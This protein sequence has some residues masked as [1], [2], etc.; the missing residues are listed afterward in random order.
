MLYELNDVTVSLSGREILTHTGMFI[1]GN[2]KIALVGKNG[3][4]K[5][6]LLNLIMG[7][8]SPDRDDKRTTEAV[9]QAR[10]L[11]IEILDQIPFK[12]MDITFYEALKE[13]L[14]EIEE[15]S[16]EYFDREYEIDRMLCGLGLD[17]EDKYKNISCFSGG[18]IT[19]LGIICLLLKQPDILLLDE[20]TNHLDLAGIEW[21]EEY[22][23]SF[24]GAVIMISHDRFFLDSVADVT[25]ELED[26]KL[27]RYAGGY[28]EYKKEKELRLAALQKAYDRYIAEKSRLEELDKRFKSRPN[29]AA[30]ARAKRSQLERLEEVKPPKAEGRIDLKSLEQPAHPGPKWVFEAEHLKIGYEKPLYETSLR[31]KRGEKIGVIGENGSGKSTLIKTVAGILPAISGK[32]T[33]GNNVK[34]GYY[35]QM[36]SRIYSEKNLLEHFGEKF[37]SLNEGEIRKKLAMWRFFGADVYKK[38]D[39]LS[40]GEKA[41]LVM[42]ELLNERPNFLIL[43]EPTNHMD[44]PAKEALEAVLKNYNAAMLIVSH[45]RYFI[46]RLAGS[47]IITGGDD[48]YCYPFGYEHYLERKRNLSVPGRLPGEL[49]SEDAALISRLKAVPKKAP[50]QSREL[51]V[52]IQQFNWAMDQAD[53]DLLAAQEAYENAMLSSGDIAAWTR[54]EDRYT[55]ACIRWYEELLKNE[56]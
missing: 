35:D 31:I 1:K 3:A 5:T 27:T 30:F 6:T 14:P 50:I 16:R 44:I 12:G 52:H 54:A 10:S 15:G 20:P 24:K 40:G 22:L 19:R 42:A 43:D 34:I 47:L 28:T 56:E 51:P 17:K 46:S 8:L 11:K 26:G 36:S 23:K 55:A 48:I 7:K 41:K 29:K 49:S 33:L 25:I 39:S 13:E 37:P 53:K 45:D 32:H 18:E 21:L 9:K 2:E 4:G 38:V